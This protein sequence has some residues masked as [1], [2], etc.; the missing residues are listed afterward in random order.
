MTL[1]HELMWQVDQFESPSSE[2]WFQFSV[3]TGCY[4]WPIVSP[5]L[6][7]RAQILWLQDL[8]AGMVVYLVQHVAETNFSLLAAGMVVYTG[9]VAADLMHSH[10]SDWD[11]PSSQGCK[12][13]RMDHIS[14]VAADGIVA[15]Q[16]IYQLQPQ[17]GLE[18]QN[19]LA[20]WGTNL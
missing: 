13:W 3:E 15:S 10:I 16:E 18:T 2:W 19:H 14:V 5:N 4:W 11:G 9:L 6:P 8:A 17:I 20:M 1:I 12:C 7:M